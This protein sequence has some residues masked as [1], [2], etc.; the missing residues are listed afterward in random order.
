MA[1]L[2]ELIAE[3]HGSIREIRV[4]ERR[5]GDGDE[6]DEMD[7]MEKR[8]CRLRGVYMMGIHQREGGADE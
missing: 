8:R 3:R 5:F 4:M 2:T 1:A 6:R 7:E